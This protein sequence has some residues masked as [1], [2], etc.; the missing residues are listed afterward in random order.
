MRRSCVGAAGGSSAASVTSLPVRTQQA[1]T[2]QRTPLARVHDTPG[3][4]RGRG[5]LSSKRT[6]R[7]SNSG[8]RPR[9]VGSSVWPGP[10]RG[11]ACHRGAASSP[12]STLTRS[13]P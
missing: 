10:C 11:D 6:K 12:P 4:E 2:P 8:T 1:E 3:S 9:L 13:S 7:A 5:D